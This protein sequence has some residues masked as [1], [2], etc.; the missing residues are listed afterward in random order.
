MCVTISLCLLSC[1]RNTQKK[2]PSTKSI[3]SRKMRKFAADG[4]D[5]GLRMG[6][7]V[8]FVVPASHGCRTQRMSCE[9]RDLP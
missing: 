2:I 5:G 6:L 9:E 8:P 3:G 4:T 1:R 7:A